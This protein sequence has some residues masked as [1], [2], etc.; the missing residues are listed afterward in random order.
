[1]IGTPE[2]TW[3]WPHVELAAPAL[4]Y[5]DVDALVGAA[6]RCRAEAPTGDAAAMRCTLAPRLPAHVTA[7]LAAR[8]AGRAGGS[9]TDVE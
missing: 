6:R 9:S 5:R 1:L 4:G 7:H 2:R 3:D 8:A